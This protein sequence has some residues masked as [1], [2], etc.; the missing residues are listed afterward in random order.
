M[1]INQVSAALDNKLEQLSQQLQVLDD[2]IST[3]ADSH[4]QERLEKDKAALEAIR[5]KMIKSKELAWQAHRLQDE[6]NEQKRARQR[7]IG[8]ALCGLSLLG[9]GLLVA[10]V[11]SQS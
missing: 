5:R 7:L 11:V 8:L 6:N 2:K 3:T 4:E 10:V 9:A 1:H